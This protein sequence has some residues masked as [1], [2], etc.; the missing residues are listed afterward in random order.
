M[1]W[2][3]RL[4]QWLLKPTPEWMV[5]PTAMIEAYTT[6]L[7]E[8]EKLRAWLAQYPHLQPTFEV[9]RPSKREVKH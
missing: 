7:I 8:E 9:L 5:A 4:A 1:T 3:Y 6:I 2:R